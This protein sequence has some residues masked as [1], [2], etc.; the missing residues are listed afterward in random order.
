MRQDKAL[1]VAEK[2]S[3]LIY[4]S[5]GFVASERKSAFPLHNKHKKYQVNSG[6][7]NYNMTQNKN[8]KG[9]AKKALSISLVAAMLATSNVPVWASGFEAVDPTAEGFAVE[10]PVS[11]ETTSAADISLQSDD[12]N[13]ENFNDSTI[14]VAENVSWGTPVTVEGNLTDKDGNQAA[15]YYEWWVGGVI[16]YASSSAATT[17]VSSKSYT[18][19]QE[20]YNKSIALRIY[21]KNASNGIIYDRT[22]S[23]GTVAAQAIALPKPQLNAS[24]TYTG[25]EQKIEPE[26]YTNETFSGAYAGLTKEYI[27]VVY[28]QKNE[29]Y[30]DVTGN[31]AISVYYVV[32]EK[33]KA[34][35]YTGTSD[36]VTYT[37][38]KKPLAADDF[39]L[40]VKNDSYEYTG[41]KISLTK[42]DIILKEKA[43]GIDVTASV[44][45]VDSD[46][47]TAVGDN[48]KA[49]IYSY[50]ANIDTTLEA[51]KSVWDNYEL[52]DSNAIVIESENTYSIVE[53][54]FSNATAVLNQTYYTDV[55]PSAVIN[56][57]LA[58]KNLVSITSNGKTITLADLISTGWSLR[59][60][61]AAKD[62][63]ENQTPGTVSGGVILEADNTNDG[64]KGQVAMNLVL[65]GGV[66][67]D[68]SIDGKVLD[69]VKPTMDTVNYSEKYIAKAYDLKEEGLQIV[70][71][72]GN[73]II[74]A[75]N[76]DITYVPDSTNAGIIKATIKGNGSYAGEQ[77]VVYFAIEPDDVNDSDVSTADGDLTINYDNNADASLYA[78]AFDL[79]IKTEL[80][81][82]STATLVEGT[83]YTVSYFYTEG[84]KADTRVTTNVDA[85]G[86]NAVGD[87]V[88]TKIT[89]TKDVNYNDNGIYYVSK[90]LVEKSI[91]NV[92]VIV[93][94]DSYTY[95]GKAITPTVIV[96][97]GSRYLYQDTDYTLKLNNNINVGT[98][99]VTIEAKDGS[100]YLKGSETSRTFTIT[101]ANA[102]DVKVTF[103]QDSY[104]YTG[105]QIQPEIQSITLNGVNVTSQF[106]ISKDRLVYGENVNAGEDMGSVTVSPKTGNKNFT[107]TKTAT[108]DIKGKLLEGDIKVYGEDGKEI[109]GV[110]TYRYTGSAIEF[111]KVEFIPDDIRLDLTEG[112]DYEIVYIDNV[113]PV[114]GNAHVAV[115]AKGNYENPGS[116]T[117]ADESV[118]KNVVASKEFDITGA[119]FSKEDITVENGI[120]AGGLAVK[121]QVTVKVND[122]TLVEGKDYE[123]KY[124]VATDATTGKPYDLEVKGIG[125]WADSN[126]GVAYDFDNSWGIDKRDLAD[127]DV[128][129]VKGVT[130][131]KIGDVT[132]DPSNYTV[133]DNGDGSYTVTAV[134][135][136]KN[137]KG[138]VTVYE[139]VPTTPDATTL[140]VT[141]RTTSTVSLSWDKVD[142][143]EGYTI[144]FRSEYDTEMSRKI[145]F[146]GDQTTWTQTGLQ[147]GTKYFYAMRS[148]VKDD[149]G[150]YIFSDVSPTQRGTT[151]PIAA[152][153]ASVSVSNGKIKV[154]LAG[155][156]AGAEM[157]SMCR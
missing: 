75:S 5:D 52:N 131:V 61:D 155:E 107:G 47:G 142:G 74:P 57:I 10:A 43:T 115:V 3:L 73:T 150:N 93:N 146:D 30:T 133:K 110:P 149:E 33:G 156:A 23:A 128:T 63:L 20:D 69:T 79:T 64:F 36:A 157:Y 84:S 81:D 31:D 35:G 8:K 92:T 144:W 40:T 68:V 147:P 123:L 76:Y 50:N 22:F 37:I 152:R 98:A 66:F 34:L 71:Y 125:A 28:T 24:Y 96:K 80:A 101:P 48:Y 18:P 145:I 58:N 111:A 119:T 9:I 32:N 126:N 25:K 90:K 116:I 137:L 51:T 41:N 53:R 62:A 109:T 139:S 130:T 83:D 49:Q 44:K 78:D 59:L 140:T 21:V 39:V 27:D 42:D 14:K 87:Y 132:V 46:A 143:A 97:D 15:Y 4:Q 99:T 141:D 153:I 86:E 114:N 105:R 56:H 88:T 121:P 12:V 77:K 124:D 135:N 148:W 151:K 29:N 120:Y 129:V 127:C 55:T 134:A 38:T 104:S 117:A 95:T 112:V 17:P 118:I 65:A 106:S 94:P 60:T 70:S 82:K 138:E 13:L 113:Y 154:N 11:E 6:K 67:G 26:N 16:R 103:E 108:F 1:K 100:G 85:D 2:K 54:N 102:E 45:S 89:L 122:Y 7:G 19:T 72:R 136:H 91:E